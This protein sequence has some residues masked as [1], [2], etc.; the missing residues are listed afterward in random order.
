MSRAKLAAIVLA[1]GSS[2]RFGSDKLSAPFRCLPLVRHAIAAARAAPV[3]R[4][5]VV[6]APALDIGRWD[7]SPPVQVERIASPA[8]SASLKAGIAAAGDVAGAFVFLGD[9]PL[10]PHDLAGKLAAV[11]AGNYAAVPRGSSGR[12]G[13]PVLLSRRAFAD[14]ATL[15]G[16]EGAGKLLKSRS[17]IA[18][19]DG[20]AETIHLDVDRAEDIARLEHWGEDEE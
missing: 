10:V 12:N 15:G 11:L 17:D 19:V 4:V 14:I 7:D 13:H 20:S 8:L 16:D 1:A 2:R 3:E 9:M 6:A 5:I 18:F